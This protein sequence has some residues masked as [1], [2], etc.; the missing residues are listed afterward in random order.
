[1]RL[2]RVQRSP[3]ATYEAHSIL[4]I[5]ISRRSSVQEA[6]GGAERRATWTT[7]STS[8]LV[9]PNSAFRC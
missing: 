6:L 4:A 9:Y 2:T 1:M 5:R 7:W 8:E 3:D